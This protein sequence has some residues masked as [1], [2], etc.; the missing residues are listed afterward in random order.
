MSFLE[1]LVVLLIAVIILKPEDYVSLIKNIRSLYKYFR[2]VRSEIETEISK[3]TDSDDS[4][5][6]SDE[7][8]FYI[9]KILDLNEKYI[10]DYSLEDVKAQYHKLLFKSKINRKK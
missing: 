10:G 2:S 3:I 9:Q 6:S 7:V 8:N 1:I 4:K 5:I